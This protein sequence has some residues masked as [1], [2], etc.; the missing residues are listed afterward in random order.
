M[1][2]VHAMLTIPEDCLDLVAMLTEKLG[3][4]LRIAGDEDGAAVVMPPMPEAERP[5]RM[6][7]GL[8]LREGLT[9]AALAGLLDVPQ[10]HISAYEKNRR[11]I[12]RDK[13]EKLARIL[14]SVPSN[15]I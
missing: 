10:S 6:L 8:R 2:T 5:G 13:A 15:F 3:G 4:I 7:R 14:H 1:S 9:Q 12:P 11:P